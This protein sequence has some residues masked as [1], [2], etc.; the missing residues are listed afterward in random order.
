MTFKILTNDRKIL[1]QSRVRTCNKGGAFENHKSLKEADKIAPG[2]VVS[3]A[4]G[5]DDKESMT[6]KEKSQTKA[7]EVVVPETVEEDEDEKEAQLIDKV[8][9]EAILSLG[10]KID[11][12]GDSPDIEV[13]GAERHP[14]KGETKIS[15]PQCHGEKGWESHYDWINRLREMQDHSNGIHCRNKGTQLTT[16]DV[17]VLINRTHITNPN[18]NGEQLSAVIDQVEKTKGKLLT[19]KKHYT[20]FGP[21]LVTRSPKK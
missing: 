19:R 1:H 13:N 18:K 21:R 11:E 2:P 10:G 17:S 8:T 12:E 14:P 5:K 4:I 7:P 15:P 20:S 9:P 6:S 3:T 16:L